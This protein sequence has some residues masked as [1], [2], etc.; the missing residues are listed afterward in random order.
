LV[1]WLLPGVASVDTEQHSATLPI[2]SDSP[3]TAELD[4]GWTKERNRLNKHKSC[5][6][7][8]PCD[9]SRPLKKASQSNKRGM[10]VLA[11]ALGVGSE[12]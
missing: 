8:G 5:V 7:G 1:G 11:L 10:I 3:Q 6:E 12:R 4:S 2:I 9:R